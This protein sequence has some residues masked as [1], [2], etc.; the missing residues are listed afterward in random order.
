MNKIYDVRYGVTRTRGCEVFRG[1]VGG[2]ESFGRR[3]HDEKEE[4]MERLERRTGNQRSG[5]HQGKRASAG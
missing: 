2:L 3:R 1:K 5:R 4:R